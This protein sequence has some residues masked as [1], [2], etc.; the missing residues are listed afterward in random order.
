MRSKPRFETLAIKSVEMDMGGFTPV[1]TPIYL[2]STYK[3]S[4]DGSFPEDLIYSRNDNPNRQVLE[5]SLA[6]LEQGDFAYAFSSG[7]A[8][9]SAVFQSLKPKDHVLLPDDIYYAVRKLMHEVFER[10]QLE[11]S[12]VDM[13]NP[14]LVKAS[15]RENTRLLW[16]ETPSNPLL[17]ITDIEKIDALTKKIDILIAV[18][19]TWSTP[20]IQNPLKLGAAL[21]IHSSTKYLGGHSDVVGGCV[22]TNDKKLAERIKSIQLLSG[23][24]PSPFD[25]WLISRGIQTLHLRISKQSENAFALAKW[26]DKHPKVKQV[27]YP[28][29]LSQ[30][31]SMEEPQL[32]GGMLSVQLACNEQRCM[33]D[34][35]QLI[36]FK[37][38]TSLGGVESLVEH[39]RSVEGPDSTT[40]DNLLRISVGIEHIDDLINDWETALQVVA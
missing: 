31:D 18:D 30:Q 32:F 25:C 1:S 11:Y 4:A 8:A 33:Q 24:V 5:K 37:T 12:M 20:V 34:T 13:S 21:V 15:I 38:A 17:K 26:L 39:R 40:P 28:G 22:I 9:I 23:A 7:M 35:N 6:T 19:N 16:I 10:W 2:S 36:H 29:L 14:E 3:R 27:N